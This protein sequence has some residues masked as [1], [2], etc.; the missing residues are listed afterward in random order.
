MA[1]TYQLIDALLAQKLPRLYGHLFTPEPSGLGLLHHELFEP[2]LRTLFL[3]PREGLGVEVATRVWDVM[4]FEGD[5]MCVRTAVAVLGALE[6]NL[7]GEREEVLG[8]L[9]WGG[10][11]GAQ[12]WKVGDED[13]FMAK[14]RA[15]GK[16]DKGAS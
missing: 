8:L 5:R 4:V 2:M 7:Y 6:G 13:G 16:H 12:C 9:G 14:V 11:G 10:G 3:G 15:V 1:R